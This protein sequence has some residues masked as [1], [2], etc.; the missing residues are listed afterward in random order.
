MP[1][2]FETLLYLALFA[3]LIYFLVIRPQQKRMREHQN[4]VE[5]IQPGTRVLLTS[6]IFATVLEV[7]DTQM[8]VE[9]APGV[10]VTILKQAVLRLAKE[11]EEEF[12]ITDA[13]SEEELDVPAEGQQSETDETNTSEKN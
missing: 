8:F 12:E 10:E 13:E 2:G 1:T 11:D 7:A 5:A 6:G 9:L 3:V 4:T